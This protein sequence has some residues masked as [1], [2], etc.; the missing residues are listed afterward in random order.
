METRQTLEEQIADFYNSLA[1]AR[2]ESL[3]SVAVFTREFLGESLL[4]A[5]FMIL[6]EPMGD[7]SEVTLQPEIVEPTGAAPN[8]GKFCREK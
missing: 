1:R 3:E 2:L 5:L 4:W 7:P 6:V 8:V